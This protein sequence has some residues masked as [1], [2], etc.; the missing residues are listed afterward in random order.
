VSYINVNFAQF[1]PKMPP[2]GD[3]VEAYYAAHQTGFM[4]PVQ[5]KLEYLTLSQN[6]FA[7]GVDAATAAS[8][9]QAALNQLANLTFE[10]AGSLSQAASNFHVPVQTTP[11]LN[12]AEP[13]SLLSNPLVLQAVMSNS[14]LN[15]R[16]N[17]AVI[18][19]SPTQAVVVRV[20]SKQAAQ[21]IP[22]AQVKP[23]IVSAI[24]LQK[25]EQAAALA[26]Q[27]M[28][29]AIN[30]GEPLSALATANGLKV[31]TASQLS[32]QSKNL[33]L[34]LLSVALSTG[35]GQAQVLP[36]QA[37]MT[38]LEV[39]GVFPN[40]KPATV[41]SAKVISGLWSQIEETEFLNRLQSTASIKIN[42]ALL[43]Q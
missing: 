10:N 8:N 13:T 20:A 14:V 27:S 29:A 5:V 6:D 37:G 18:H 36:S 39:T 19:M 26:V 16:N 11:L 3:E 23:A 35:A 24:N 42:T 7:K 43:S 32:L 9:Y 41:I 17:S 2:T 1:M 4:T 38:V 34:S 40:P 22:L 15:Q 25:A 21:P 12:T 30:K 33:P 28:V 31:E